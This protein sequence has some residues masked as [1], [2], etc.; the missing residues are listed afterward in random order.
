V[1]YFFNL[2]EIMIAARS[3]RALARILNPVV[4]DA[5]HTLTLKLPVALQ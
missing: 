4:S 5:R 2:V 3:D 1:G